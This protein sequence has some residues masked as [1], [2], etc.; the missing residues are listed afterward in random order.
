MG[1]V[2]LHPNR[3]ISLIVID[4][5]PIVRAGVAAVVAA[6]A[7][8]TI[9]LSVDSVADA[10]RRPGRRPTDE[11]VLTDLGDHG[12]SASDRI[13]ALRR[14]A[15]DRPVLVYSALPERPWA[16]VAIEV[17]ASGFISRYSPTDQL[18]DALRCVAGGDR[19][20]TAEGAQALAD[21][22]SAASDLTVRER[23]VLRLLVD[24]NRIS[25][26]AQI[27]NI[28]VKTASSHKGNL[29]RKLGVTTLG[30]LIRYAIDHRLV[31]DPPTLY[32]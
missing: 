23:E 4:P 10:L 11:V 9:G 18:L 25:D 12:G 26:V 19:Y 20:I 31:P 8:I 5:Q 3:T 17:G 22:I 1:V 7:D 21:H 28:S 2:G 13:A 30:G 16:A 15:P 27:L 6:T 29:Q 24:G 14:A 32:R